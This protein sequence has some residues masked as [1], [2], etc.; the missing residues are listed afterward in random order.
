[1]WRVGETDKN[2]SYVLWLGSAAVAI[3]LFSL[4]GGYRLDFEG[5]VAA[6]R[7]ALYQ[8][9]EGML[10]PAAKV[11]GYVEPRTECRLFQV[12]AKSIPNFRVR[13]G[14]LIGW[15]AEGYSFDPPITTR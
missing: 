15:T 10:D 5:R 3:T 11:V 12:G 14:S 8:E 6:K 1:M 9:W 4:I 2:R 7:V 13:C